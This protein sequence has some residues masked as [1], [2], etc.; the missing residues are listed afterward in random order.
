MNRGWEKYL[1]SRPAFIVSG[2]GATQLANESS[3]LQNA[4]LSQVDRYRCHYNYGYNVD[5]THIC[6]GDP[7]H[8]VGKGDSGGPLGLFVEYNR[9]ERFIQF[10]IVSHHRAPYYGVAVFTN[11][12]SYSG[13][14]GRVIRAYN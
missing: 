4:V 1:Y 5:Y 9:E 8:Y 11:V 13:W 7:H 2:W 14:I 3:I 10:G 12:L 6:A